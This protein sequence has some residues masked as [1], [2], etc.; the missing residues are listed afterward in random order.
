MNL[1][2]QISWSDGW[3]VPWSASLG[4]QFPFLT[5]LPICAATRYPAVTP[6]GKKTGE[7]STTIT[8]ILSVTSVTNEETHT[9]CGWER[10]VTQLL[11]EEHASDC[12][13]EI[14]DEVVVHH[15]PW[16]QFQP[17][18]VVRTEVGPQLGASQNCEGQRE[19][20]SGL[21]DSGRTN[22]PV[23]W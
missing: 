7:K 20:G 13:D 9:L 5:G 16:I 18:E 23:S 3:R 10:D 15:A 12:W 21:W 17:F 22:D 2:A 1:L 14:H 19:V 4:V 6:R 8:R 11:E